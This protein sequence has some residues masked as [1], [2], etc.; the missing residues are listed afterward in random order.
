MA[1]T[2]YQ[3]SSIQDT[4]ELEV[5]LALKEN[6][7]KTLKVGSFGQVKSIDEENSIAEV[8]LFPSYKN[9]IEV[10]IFATISTSISVKELDVVVVL[11]LDNNFKQSLKQTLKEQR[12]TGLDTKEITLHSINYGVIIA[13]M[14][15]GYVPY[16][17]IPIT[18]EEID[19]AFND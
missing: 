3:N 17:M 11:F 1:D 12:R 16:E 19:E 14:S 10:T 13:S 7:F 15:K 9:E 18:N 4:S 2:R 6:I 5:L 8:V